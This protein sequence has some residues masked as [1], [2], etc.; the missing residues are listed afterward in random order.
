[1]ANI[2][3]REY[4]REIEGLIEAGKM[5][6]AIA[7]CQ[8]ILKTYSM[9]IETY[10]L[11]GKAFLEAHKYADAADIFQRILNAVPDDFIAH[12]GMSIIR[13]DESKL[14]ESI[15]HMER[16]YEV[17]PSNPAIQGELRR[18][19]GKRDGVEPAKIRLSREALANMYAQGELYNQA[20]AEIRAILTD[21]PDR[22]DL[23]VMLA[24]SYFRAGQKVEAA[25]MAVH[26]LKKYPYCVD[27]LRILV[28]VLPGTSRAENVQVYRQRLKLLDPYSSDVT[29]SLFQTDQTPDA[30]VTLEHL[31][32]KVN[33]QSPAQSTWASSLGINLNDG[34]AE[35]PP[36]SSLLENQTGNEIDLTPAAS[37]FSQDEGQEFNSDFKQP[38]GGEDWASDAI[39]VGNVASGEEI[40]EGEMPDWLRS[41]LPPEFSSENP[42]KEKIFED[43]PKDFPG[44]LDSFRSDQSTAGSTEPLDETQPSG[45]HP[46]GQF[47]FEA[48]DEEVRPSFTPDSQIPQSNRTSD[49]DR[50]TWLGNLA[51]GETPEPTDLSVPTEGIMP[52]KEEKEETLAWLQS[53]KQEPEGIAEQDPADIPLGLDEV[54][55]RIK[56]ASETAI[57]ASSQPTADANRE[58]ITDDSLLGELDLPAEGSLEEAPDW[59]QN[60]I[61]ETEPEPVEYQS[62]GPFSFSEESEAQTQTVENIEDTEPPLADISPIETPEEVTPSRS[63]DTTFTTWLSKQE[64]SQIDTGVEPVPPTPEPTS[65]QEVDLPDW[66]KDLDASMN[67]GNAIPSSTTQDPEP[68]I[69]L[70]QEQ[71]ILPEATLPAIPEEKEKELAQEETDL[72]LQ[73]TPTSATEWKPEEGGEHIP[74]IPETSPSDVEVELPIDIIEPT[75]QV[76]EPSVQMIEPS[77]LP[78]I[79]L[80]T[81]EEASLNTAKALLDNQQVNEAVKEYYRIIKKGKSLDEIIHELRE[82]VNQHP[83]EINLWQVLGDAYMK[84]NRLQD[85]L[86]A[87]T[88]AE[89]LLR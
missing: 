84:T 42:P 52:S 1:M 29:D 34:E 86:D 16:A 47:S 24:R 9:H 89:E 78:S 30:E 57:V 12:V 70:K 48:G 79:P 55:D 71:D 56:M 37:I 67:Q 49:D 18:L 35:L 53:L 20:I 10:Q 45:I 39:P 36:T 82:A 68:P 51:S 33:T 4:N 62:D 21:D 44:W 80:K 61:L 15:W 11:L 60:P 27:A 38:R 75:T 8:H 25:E 85:A 3:L 13:D 50:M 26:L 41:Q 74:S 5:D 59:I 14:N 7:H 28:E 58:E 22:P 83:L 66:L 63:E 69:W 23:Q 54:P 77:T 64:G 40:S 65:H 87:Y 6:R 76:K 31:E 43:T 17:Q 19:Y 72:P 46:K 2:S 32:Y 73:L 88:K 81:K